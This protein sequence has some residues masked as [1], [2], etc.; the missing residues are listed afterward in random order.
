MLKMQAGRSLETVEAI[1]IRQFFTQT[2][3]RSLPAPGYCNRRAE[4][5]T[6]E[7]K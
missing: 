3:R 7:P 4:K 5:V 6:I 1:A 2:G